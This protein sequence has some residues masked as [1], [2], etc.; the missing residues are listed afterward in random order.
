MEDQKSYTPKQ[1]AD[2]ISLI[3]NYDKQFT[4]RARMMARGEA[5]NDYLKIVNDLIE[6][7][8]ARLQNEIPSNVLEL[9]CD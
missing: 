8:A 9:L 3:R 6:E 2:M 7:T 5:D 1:V 4:D